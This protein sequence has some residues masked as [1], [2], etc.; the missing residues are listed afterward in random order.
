MKLSCG[1]RKWEPVPGEVS[2]PSGRE[3]AGCSRGPA[4]DLGASAPVVQPPEVLA[5]WGDLCALLT[6]LE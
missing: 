3:G 5:P 2:V 6:W 1:C 4:P